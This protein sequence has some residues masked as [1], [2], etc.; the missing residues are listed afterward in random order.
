LLS[1]QAIVANEA[2]AASSQRRPRLGT[3]GQ[4]LEPA[5]GAQTLVALS[6]VVPA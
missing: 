2:Y 4:L 3:A 5:E 6:E 1:N